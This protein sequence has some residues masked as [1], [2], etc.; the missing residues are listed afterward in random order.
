VSGGVRTRVV[1]VRGEQMR[2]VGREARGGG[3]PAEQFSELVVKGQ[4]VLR[5][6][7]NRIDFNKQFLTGVR[8]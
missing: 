7:R 5:K 1:V 6:H 2:G 4:P 3:E 8:V